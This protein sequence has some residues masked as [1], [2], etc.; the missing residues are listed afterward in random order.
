M[1]KNKVQCPYSH[2][3]DADKYEICPVCNTSAMSAAKSEETQVLKRVTTA[4]QSDIAYFTSEP[5]QIEEQFAGAYP[6]TSSVFGVQR[7]DHISDPPATKEISPAIPSAQAQNEPQPGNREQPDDNAPHIPPPS[8]SLQAAVDAV[9]SHKDNEDVKTV[10]MWNAPAGSEPVVGWL[11]CVKGQYFGQSFNLK[12]GNNFIG[13]AMNM[14]VHLAQEESVSRNKH[15]AITYEPNNQAFYIQQGESS[16]LTYLNG[17]MVLTPTRMNTNDKIQIGQAEF[18][19]IPLCE[20]GF[21][22]E[23]YMESSK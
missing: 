8:L 14:D 7:E 2:Y 21:R 1:V 19:L 4:S 20:Y 9:V 11:V 18:I 13:R 5:A 12:N 15:C 16:G 10:A 17:E 23:Y 22:W 6:P 3:Y